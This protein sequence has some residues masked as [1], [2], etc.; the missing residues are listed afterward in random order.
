[1]YGSS[2]ILQM[3]GQSNSLDIPCLSDK[4]VRRLRACLDSKMALTLLAASFA[5]RS[6]AKP[7]LHSRETPVSESIS[8][9]ALFQLHN[10]K[11]ID[12]AIGSVKPRQRRHSHY[13]HRIVVEHRRHVFRREFVRRI[14]YQETG[15]AH[16]T[17][18][19]NNTSAGGSDQ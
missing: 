1:V 5:H 11:Q 7:S 16:R 4:L 10:W 6:R 13:C 15:F 3:R 18:S 9:C 2:P 12:S 8:T 17:I 14:G 19:N